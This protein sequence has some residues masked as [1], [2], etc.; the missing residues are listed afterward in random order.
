MQYNSLESLHKIEETEVSSIYSDVSFKT[1]N[2]GWGDQSNETTAKIHD[3]DTKPE[4]ATS[5]KIVPKMKAIRE[6][7]SLF[8][9]SL[10]NFIEDVQKIDVKYKLE[11]EDDYFIKKSVERT[12]SYAKIKS[13]QKFY[14]L[15]DIFERLMKEMNYTKCNC[16]FEDGEKET[17]I[18]IINYTD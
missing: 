10:H 6:M 15:N 3:F 12:Q 1:I 17:L 14:E 4:V 9:K 11:Y 7:C 2:G 5:V 13:S 18:S 16:Y 8:K